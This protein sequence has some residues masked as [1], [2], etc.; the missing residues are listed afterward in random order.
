M[1]VGGTIAVVAAADVP[2]EEIDAVVAEAREQLASG[3]IED[4]TSSP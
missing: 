2:Q 4:A 1:P 3:A